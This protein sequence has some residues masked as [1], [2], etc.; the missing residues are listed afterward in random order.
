MKV[1]YIAHS[2][3]NMQNITACERVI[4]ANWYVCRYIFDAAD[5]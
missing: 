3:T 2:E 5:E 4:F 1:Y